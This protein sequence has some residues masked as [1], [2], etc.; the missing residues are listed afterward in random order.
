MFSECMT[1]DQEVLKEQ[2]NYFWV[3]IRNAASFAI[4]KN[5][6]NENN[7]LLSVNKI[8]T[9]SVYSKC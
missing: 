5:I 9:C 1:N 7:N 2:K 8:G 4:E 6:E 3:P